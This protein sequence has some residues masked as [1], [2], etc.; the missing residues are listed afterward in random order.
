MGTRFYLRS[1]PSD[2]A[3]RPTGSATTDPDQGHAGLSRLVCLQMSRA[4]GGA[5][6]D[7]EFSSAVPHAVGTMDLVRLFISPALANQ[8][9]AIGQQFSYAAGYSDS[10]EVEE[11]H[12]HAFLY[13]WRP[14][15]G[16]VATLFGDGTALAGACRSE[17][18]DAGAKPVW[19]T[20][21]W[22]ALTA[23]IEVRLRDRIV[24]EVWA[25]YW[26]E[27]PTPSHASSF[28]FN[29]SEDGHAEGEVV[30]PPDCASY[31][32]FGSDL[33]LGEDEMPDPL[34]IL[35]SAVDMEVDDVNVGFLDG[36]VALAYT[37]T[38]IEHSVEQRMGIQRVD[39]IAERLTVT[40][41][42]LEPTLEA[43]RIA[44]GQP[45]SSLSATLSTLGVGSSTVV[46]EHKLVLK[47]KAPGTN[48]SRTITCHKAVAIEASAH[49]YAREG[50]VVIP[51]TFVLV[52][53]NTKE[54]GFKFLTITDAA[55]TYTFAT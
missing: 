26:G 40:A 8:T 29:G 35:V 11:W 5:D 25:H 33:L 18:P 45:A 52:E 20:A 24:L 44:Y 53:D 9:L 42:L 54:A 31:L 55:G 47:G 48:K 19:R 50:R 34:N 46:T 36:A 27:A 32:Q 14:G 12:L 28:H 13:L 16:Y 7:A 37:P 39:R 15:I 43:I 38:H 3:G 6:C 41:N 22:P 17:T 21:T 10:D 30:D 2:Q 23:D 4:K 49:S 1:T 51:V